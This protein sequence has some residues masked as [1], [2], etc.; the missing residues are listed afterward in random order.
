MTSTEVLD[1]VRERST[2]TDPL[3]DDWRVV[4]CPA[5]IKTGIV[6]HALLA[7]QLRGRFPSTVTGLHGLIAL[8]GPPGT[9]KTTLARGLA[10]ALSEVYRG[11]EVRL[12]EVNP[13]G[14]MSGEHGRSQQL[15]SEL[16]TEHLPSLADDGTPTVV[17]LDEVESMAVSRSA[18][19][20]SAN[21]VDVHRATDAV[22]TA[23][24]ELAA[25]HTNLVFIVTS[26]FVTGLDIAF[27]SRAD[28]VID[29]GLP[30]A[31]ALHQII[32]D[33]L[34]SLGRH[35]QNLLTLAEDPRL[36]SL[37]GTVE[38]IDGRQA[39]KLVMRALALRPETAVDAGKLTFDD[40]SKAAKQTAARIKR[41]VSH[42]RAA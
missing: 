20:L 40:L 36:R 5:E 37:A 18:A 15:V 14:L 1:A 22:L 9:G 26:N 17:L 42:V 16:L 30:A 24:D 25:S 6:H 35:H 33:V 23:M 10:G 11:A 12:L 38:G 4:I 27:L 8:V 29:V 3:A 21:P 28:A 31:D 19:S 39:R 41:E 13:H 2:T 7:F 34:R 32:A